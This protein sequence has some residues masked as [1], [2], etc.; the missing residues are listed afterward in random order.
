MSDGPGTGETNSIPAEEAGSTPESIAA[1]TARNI[2]IG[3]DQGRK[4]Q[5][6]ENPDPIMQKIPKDDFLAVPQ[7]D[8]KDLFLQLSGND[9]DYLLNQFTDDERENF[10]KGFSD[11]EKQAILRKQQMRKELKGRLDEATADDD[12]DLGE[13]QDI[14]DPNIQEQDKEFDHNFDQ[15]LTEG[16]TPNGGL[17]N[18]DVVKPMLAGMSKNDAVEL[19]KAK[20]ITDLNTITALVSDLPDVGEKDS[21]SE[22]EVTEK[23]E[24]LQQT[25]EVWRKE[26]DDADTMLELQKQ[27][28]PEKA[29]EINAL[30]R[31]MRNLSLKVKDFFAEGEPGRKYA[32]KGGKLLYFAILTAIVLLLLEMNIIYKATSNRGRR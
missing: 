30:Q 24:A 28:N 8:Q 2:Q 12:K 1:R 22:E 7:A 5:A 19:L 11:E 15:A 32:K 13:R 6:M 29:E 27:K 10:L 20:D 21:M 17:N 31:K 3:V 16:R 4:Q 18:I 23:N 25:G 14:M 9:Q 26:L